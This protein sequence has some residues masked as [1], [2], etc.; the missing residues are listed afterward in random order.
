MSEGK[1]RWGGGKDHELKSKADWWWNATAE[2]PPGEW[3]IPRRDVRVTYRSHQIGYLRYHEGYRYPWQGELNSGLLTWFHPAYDRALKQL[4]EFY[5]KRFEALPSKEQKVIVEVLRSIALGT[6]NLTRRTEDGEKLDVDEE[7]AQL[8]QGVDRWIEEIQREYSIDWER[9]RPPTFF[10]VVPGRYRKL[11][12][13]ETPV[14]DERAEAHAA[15]MWP[16]IKAA[17]DK[18][19][20]PRDPQR[21]TALAV[22]LKELPDD[23]LKSFAHVLLY[24]GQKLG[25]V[26]NPTVC[27]SGWKP[28]GF[29]SRNANGETVLVEDVESI[30][31]APDADFDSKEDAALCLF[32]AMKSHGLLPESE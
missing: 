3:A 19:L 10:K 29:V 27:I 31:I 8:S 18:I 6:D 16:I 1:Y 32:Y 24:S 12:E 20:A 2:V 11:W 22:E 14:S 13:K 21:L 7:F 4:R 30:G 5:S 26:D 15:E 28:I 25:V 9:D 17:Q 23:V